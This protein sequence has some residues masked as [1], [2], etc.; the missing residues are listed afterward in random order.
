MQSRISSYKPRAELIVTA[1]GAD[2]SKLALV[3]TSLQGKVALTALQTIAPDRIIEAVRFD[4]ANLLILLAQEA[5]DALLESCREVVQAT[6]IPV[7]VFV[8]SAPHNAGTRFVRLGVSSFIV[9]GLS[10]ERLQ[11]IIETAMERHRLTSA[12][13]TE[14]LNSK[15]ELLARKKV[16][17]A[18]GLLMRQQALSE[19]EA[20]DSMRRLAMTKGL[21]LVDVAETII[22]LSD[23]TSAQ[24]K[25]TR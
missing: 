4:Q 14:L 7:I 10:E 24:Q 17:R 23:M 22:G 12:L 2:M 16:E 5:D 11:P 18:K 3:E 15:N 8:D 21:K 25:S 6:Q 20:Y 9:N 19:E 13:Q 1:A